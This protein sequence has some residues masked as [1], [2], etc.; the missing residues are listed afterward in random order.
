MSDW[1]TQGTAGTTGGTERNSARAV[2]ARDLGR[3]DHAETHVLEAQREA[4]RLEHSDG[5]AIEEAALSLLDSIAEA[6]ASLV[7]DS[8]D[9]SEGR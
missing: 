8:E 2:I 5:E 4:G 3:L 1:I 9:A 6:K 7:A